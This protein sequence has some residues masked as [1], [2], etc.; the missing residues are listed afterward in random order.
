VETE[1]INL[2]I[3]LPEGVAQV[4]HEGKGLKYLTFTKEVG[5]LGGMPCNDLNFCAA[6]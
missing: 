2:K 1:L 4:V 6:G 3:G 5:M